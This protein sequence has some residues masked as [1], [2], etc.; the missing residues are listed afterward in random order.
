MLLR[1]HPLLTY[2][3]RRSWPP[4]W[5]YCGGFDNTY[6]RGEIGLLK[7]VFVSLAKPSTRCFLIMEH[8]GAEYMGELFI[9][10]AAFCQEMYA[11]LLQYCGKTIQEIGDVDL[12]DR[13]AEHSTRSTPMLLRDHPLMRYRGVPSWPPAWIWTGGREHKYP[14]GEIGVLRRV[15]QSD[16]QPSNRCFLFIDHEESTYIG[17]LTVDD[18]AFCAQ[19][20]RFLQEHCY[21]RPIAEIGGLELP[22]TH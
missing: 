9:N 11:V 8:A 22:H 4:D 1:D 14:K 16:I 3:N 5:L 2:Q 18:H 6:P 19:I 12:I 10:D 15:A 20:V 21:N 7:I 17:D 13:N